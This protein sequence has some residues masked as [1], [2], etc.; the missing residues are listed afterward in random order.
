[1]DWWI[2]GHY[3]YLGDIMPKT[4]RT[5]PLRN[6]KFTVRFSPLDNELSALLTGIGDLGFAQMGGLSVQNELIAYREGGMNTHPHKMIGQS[7][8]PAISFARGAFA[9]QDQLWKWQKFMHSWV[10]GGINGFPGGASG[11][12]TNYRCNIVVRVFDHPYTAGDAVY[13]YD[14]SDPSTSLK[15]GNVK[16]AFKLF[17]CWP[18]AY[19]LSDL[20]AG[21]NGIMIQQLNVHHEGFSVAWTE[22]DVANIDAAN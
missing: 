18:G 22:G 4:Q 21:D 1:M 13:A 3:Q 14:S 2:N 16:L 7:D 20:N 17:N 10:N 19:G 9:T 12:A 11:D 5:D 15:P 6:F 8:F